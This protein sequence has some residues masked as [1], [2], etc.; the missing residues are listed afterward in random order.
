[1]RLF[2]AIVCQE[3]APRELRLLLNDIAS[4]GTFSL[5]FEEVLLERCFVVSSWHNVMKKV[6]I[7]VYPLV[8]PVSDGKFVPLSRVTSCLEPMQLP[9]CVRGAPPI[10]VRVLDDCHLINDNSFVQQS[11]NE[12]VFL[13]CFRQAHQ[14]IFR[15]FEVTTSV[16]YVIGVLGMMSG[17]LLRSSSFF[18]RLVVYCSVLQMRGLVLFCRQ[19]KFAQIWITATCA[20][21]LWV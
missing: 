16:E 11:F 3:L 18:P 10:L 12:E 20:R 1:M 7:D 21:F 6:C 14:E 4:F 13:Q 8:Q 5:Q 15:M 17:H 19:C 9:M 2:Q